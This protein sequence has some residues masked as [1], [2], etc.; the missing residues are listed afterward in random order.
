M[1][2]KELQALL[3]AA[4]EKQASSSAESQKAMQEEITGLTDEL[5][6]LELKHEEASKKWALPGIEEEKNFSFTKALRGLALG[7]WDDAG[8]EKEV[9]DASQKALATTPD[10]NGGFTV[11]TELAKQMIE[12]LRAETVLDQVGATWIDLNGH[13]QIEIPKMTGGATANWLDENVDIPATSQTFGNLL[14]SP[15]MVAA[16]SVSSRRLLMQS[17]QSIEGM[18]RA[19]LAKSLALAIDEKAF[20]GDGTG[21][22]PVGIIN[23]A[24]VQTLGGVNGDAVSWNNMDELQGL[25]ED[26]DAM[27]GNLAYAGNPKLWRKLKRQTVE[28]FSGQGAENGQPYVNPIMN[29]AQIAEFL[30]YKFGKSTYFPTGQTTGSSSTTTPGFFGN[31]SDLILGMWNGITLE[32]TTV[33]GGAFN[34]HQVNI[35]AVA[36]VDVAVRHGKSFAYGNFDLA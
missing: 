9:F 21:N 11:P 12:L 5:K 19:D 2:K 17:N 13:G 23:Q 25:L 32:A 4:V 22:T 36:E 16:R 7:V 18:I 6:A 24:G 34:A 27:R 8:L 15:K 31:F 1:D 3:D 29:D 26:V 14:M 28:Q 10:S 33:G 35:K 30:G 20:F